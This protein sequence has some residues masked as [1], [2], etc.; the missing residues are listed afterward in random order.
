MRNA[1]SLMVIF[2]LDLNPYI[3]DKSQLKM[4]FN[5]TT[6]IAIKF[7]S[8]LNISILLPSVAICCSWYLH[9]NYDL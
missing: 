7:I 4:P 1:V 9:F 6:Y 2:V 5:L 8:F 3:P